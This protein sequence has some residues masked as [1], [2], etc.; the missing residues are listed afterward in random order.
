VV[1][2]HPD[3]GHLGGGAAVWEAFPIKQVLLPVSLSRSPA[4][5]SWRDTAP[6]AVIQVH[7]VSNFRSVTLS[8]GAKLEVL[9]A[10]D[11]L[12]QNAIADER[13]AI[14][15]LHWRGWKILLTSD[16]GMGAELA[17][18]DVGTDVTA[19]VI[20][21]GHHRGDL[22]LSDQFLDAVDPQVIVASNSAFPIEERLIP[23][24]VA[25]WK[26]RDIKVID[27]A[28]SGGVTVLVEDSGAL[29]LEGFADH[30]QLVLPPK[31]P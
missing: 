15:K 31:N 14:F 28:K 10:P 9:Y 20:I 12:A 21:A 24:R 26:S 3:G 2:T 29:R 4:F 30:S 5:R 8:D 17:L 27:Q 25:Y 19:D 22:T 13:V 7:Q 6:A 23:R 11:P 1:I 18:L 16:A